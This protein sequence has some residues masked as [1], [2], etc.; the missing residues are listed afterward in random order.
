MVMTANVL[1][2]K[3]P[4][5]WQKLRP[6][7][8]ERIIK[9]RASATENIIFTTHAYDRVDERSIIQADVYRILR[10][11]YVDEI[12]EKDRHGGWTTTIKKRIRGGREA[13]VVT[14]IF[15]ESDNL[16]VI[17]VMWVDPK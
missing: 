12:P 6:D 5:R 16:I 7:E 3:R 8:A 13:A 15:K 9:E 17:T 14:V 1:P 11:G 10:E 2:M 4:I